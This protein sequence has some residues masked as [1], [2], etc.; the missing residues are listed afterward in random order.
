[1]HL[2]EGSDCNNGKPIDIV[3]WKTCRRIFKVL[4]PHIKSSCAT[5]ISIYSH[6]A[7]PAPPFSHQTYSHHS[8][9]TPLNL[10]L[11]S[12]T[13]KH[14]LVD[15]LQQVSSIYLSELQSS[16][17]PSLSDLLMFSVS[18]YLNFLTHTDFAPHVFLCFVLVLLSHSGPD[19]GY[20]L[21][22][23]CFCY[24]LALFPSTSPCPP[25]AKR[26]CIYQLKNL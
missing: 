1:M 23:V 18:N 3:F 13:V 4:I 14:H 22:L 24:S 17:P 25:P 11:H 6:P 7:L 5:G 15:C 2:H 26:Y 16:F 19:A 8:V 9:P 12:V 21:L 20:C 10:L